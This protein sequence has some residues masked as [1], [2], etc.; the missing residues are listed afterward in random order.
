MSNVVEVLGDLG[1]PQFR[2]HLRWVDLR[3]G[4]PAVDHGRYIA[5]TRGSAARAA[6]ADGGVSDALSVMQPASVI[7]PSPSAP[8]RAVL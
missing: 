1:S 3:D 2:G 5:G 8:R 6:L 4:D 7:A